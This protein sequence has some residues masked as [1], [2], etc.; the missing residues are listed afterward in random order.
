M[1]AFKKILTGA[2]ALAMGLTMVMTTG[3]TASAAACY[4][5]DASDTMV[6][7]ATPVFNNFCNA[8]YGIGAE[9]DFVRVRQSTNGNNEDN[10]A[11]AQYT[12]N[13]DSTCADGTQ[14]DVWNYVHNN[15]SDHLNDNGNGSA[16]AHNAKIALSAPT[17]TTSTKPFTFGATVSADNAT[18]VSDTATLN[19]GGKNVTL[20]MV[21]KSVH[22]YSSAYGAWHDL[23]DTA[24]NG[25]ANLGSPTFGSTDMWGCF[26]YR[27][28]VV[29]SVKVTEVKTPAPVLKCVLNVVADTKNKRMVTATVNGTAQNATITGYT[30]DWGDRS[31]VSNKQ[32]DTHTYGDKINSAKITASFIATYTDAAGK[33]V[34]QP[35]SG[36]DCIVP[37]SFTTTPPTTPP[38]TPPTRPTPAP[39]LVATGA[40]SVA[41]LIG[42]FAGASV[43]GTTLYRRMLSRQ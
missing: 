17:G 4:N 25:S 37:V 29:Y 7:S 5:Y 6:T 15:A 27:I 8:P 21:S 10:V 13:V 2:A 14:F 9:A 11:N 19:C 26:N 24:V 32:T 35:V 43:I 34:T 23:S 30:I 31:T 42:L 20:S 3:G 16:V 41:T 1:K 36:A 12:N 38:V 22:I 33:T 18:S 40:G 39:V 28:V